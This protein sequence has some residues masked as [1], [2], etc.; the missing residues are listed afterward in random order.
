MIFL[1][2][3]IKPLAVL[4]FLVISLNCASTGYGPQGLLFTNHS[5]GLYANQIDSG[6]EGSACAF[7]IL[8]L[9]AWGDASIGKAREKGLLT[10]INLIEQNSFSILGIYAKVCIVTKGN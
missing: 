5:I 10:K 9:L 7:S 4:I 3:L 1:S 2:H 6:K 8:G